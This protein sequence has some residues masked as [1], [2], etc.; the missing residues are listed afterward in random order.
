MD[1]HVVLQPWQ[2]DPVPWAPPKHLIVSGPYAYVR[3]PMFLA[4]LA[5]L[6]AETLFFGSIGILIWAGYSGVNHA[7]YYAY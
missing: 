4:A 6:L 3:N 5:I 2:R 7:I 1:A